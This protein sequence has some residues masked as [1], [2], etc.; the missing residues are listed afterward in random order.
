[1][2]RITLFLSIL[3]TLAVGSVLYAQD[4]DKQSTEEEEPTVDPVTSEK[5]AEMTAKEMTTSVNALLATMRDKNLPGVLEVQRLARRQ[6]DVIKLNCV[7]DKY[8]Q[9][10]QLMNI[11][12]ESAT[13]LAQAV[14]QENEKERYHQYSKITVVSEK[15]R[16]LEEE[17][18]ECVGDEL[19]YLGPTD[20]EV[21]GPDIDD[22]FDDG[23]QIDVEPP[24]YA[25]PFA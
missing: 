23:D 10:K 4:A 15:A 21:D 7:N 9:L 25:S 1:M 2:H 5:V 12:E 8:L 6:K 20:V 14:S 24:A 16:S 3:A 11:A 22:P 13:E 19:I 17:A 18:R